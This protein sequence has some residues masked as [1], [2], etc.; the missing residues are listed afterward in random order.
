MCQALQQKLA[1]MMELQKRLEQK[2]ELE[3]RKSM[4][5]VPKCEYPCPARPAGLE[6]NDF[7]VAALSSRSI[8]IGDSSDGI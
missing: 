4:L 6:F 7:C 1:L 3:I 5:S 8:A 2:R